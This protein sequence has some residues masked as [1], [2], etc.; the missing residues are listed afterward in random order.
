MNSQFKYPSSILKLSGLPLSIIKV[1]LSPNPV[2]PN[3]CGCFVRV[4]VIDE[5]LATVCYNART[6]Q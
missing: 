6:G 4:A 1:R 5:F 2:Q 3:P